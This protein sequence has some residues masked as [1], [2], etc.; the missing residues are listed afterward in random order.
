MPC[1][2]IIR[3]YQ[4]LDTM[5][6]DKLEAYS[7]NKLTAYMRLYTAYVRIYI[8]LYSTKCLQT[9]KEGAQCA[10]LCE[11]S[12][13]P[14]ARGRLNASD[15]ARHRCHRVFT[16]TSMPR[17]LCTALLRVELGLLF[18]KTLSALTTSFTKLL[19]A[20]VTLTSLYLISQSTVKPQPLPRLM[21][22][23]NVAIGDRRS[24][25]A[26]RHVIQPAIP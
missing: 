16:E 21:A 17:S 5:Q 19:K 14:Q 4:S 10:A 13:Q 8:N 12:P 26:M 1:S 7:H 25:I 9:K 15:T 23:A 22:P 18:P 3:G 24:Q 6:S 11:A 2:C 20:A